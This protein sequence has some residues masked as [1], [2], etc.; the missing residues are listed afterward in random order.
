MFFLK[1]FLWTR[2]MHLWQ[3]RWKSLAKSREKFTQF[4]KMIRKTKEFR[5][6]YSSSKFPYGHV[7]SIFDNLVENYPIKSRLFFAQCSK[8]IERNEFFRKNVFRQ[9][10]HLDPQNAV[11]TITPKNCRQI[12]DTLLLKVRKWFKKFT[13]SNKMFFLKVFLWTRKMHL[14]QPR[15][16]N[17]IESR[18]MSENDKK[19][20]ESQK[21]IFFLKIFLWTLREHFW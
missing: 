1:V 4:P 2:K 21:K 7:E 17:L 16:K 9:S 19:I 13:L 20:K 10:V 6:N 5:K 18:K 3:P 15:W 12:V 11:L 14:W 8:M